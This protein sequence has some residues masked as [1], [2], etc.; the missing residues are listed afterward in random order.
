MNGT[1]GAAALC[2]FMT[3]T[4]T[5][6]ITSAAALVGGCLAH[7]PPPAAPYHG[8]G[9]DSAWHLII[10]DRH[11]TYIGPGQ[12]PIAQ[13]RPQVIVGVAGDIYQTQRINVNIVHAPCTAAGRIYPDQVQVT[14][15]GVRR[16][17]CGGL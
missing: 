13:P 12:Q 11:V 2:H 17:G 9:S 15:D 7:P 6:A 5:L 16:N 10:D 1:G 8:I 4:R 3:Y 14:V